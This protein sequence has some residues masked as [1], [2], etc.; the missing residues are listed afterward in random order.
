[1]IPGRHLDATTF[2]GYKWM[3]FHPGNFFSETG[4]NDEIIES[5]LSIK[6]TSDVLRLSVSLKKYAVICTYV[7]VVWKPAGPQINLKYLS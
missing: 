6:Y 3:W 5:I 4:K 2:L 7:Y 1:M